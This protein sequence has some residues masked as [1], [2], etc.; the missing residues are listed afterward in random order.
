MLSSV[1]S[2]KMPLYSH[3]LKEKPT[4]VT[5]WTLACQAPLFMAFSRQEYWGELLFLSRGNL[6]NQSSNLHLLRCR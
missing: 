6:P 5:P 4:L 3:L 1:F 2:D